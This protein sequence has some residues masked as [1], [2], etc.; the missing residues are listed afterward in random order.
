MDRLVECVGISEGLVGEMM[1][2]EVAPD[3]L[4]VVQF[5]GVF[6]QP[7]DGEPMCAGGERCERALAGVDRAIVLDQD[8]RREGLSGPR[9]IEPIELLEMG[10]EI[11][12]ALGRAGV[13]DEFAD[14]VIERAQQRDLLCLS[15]GWDT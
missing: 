1:R 15:W 8:D 9:T 12:A 6:G 7:L 14:R 13:D 3:G 2:L 11:A 4:D 5:R 10:D